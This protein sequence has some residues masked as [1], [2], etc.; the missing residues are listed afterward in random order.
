[1]HRKI[2]RDRLAQVLIEAFGMDEID[3]ELH[4]AV[5]LLKLA[6]PNPLQWSGVAS[7]SCALALERLAGELHGLMARLR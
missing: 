2:L 5:T 3:F 1:M 6:I 7:N 4:R